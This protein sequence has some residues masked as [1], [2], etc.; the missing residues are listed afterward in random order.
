MLVSIRQLQFP[1]LD[2]GVMRILVRH[3]SFVLRLVEFRGGTVEDRLFDAPQL[4]STV[5]DWPLLAVTLAGRGVVRDGAAAACVAGRELIWA[6]RG[7]GIRA[8]SEPSGIRAL[9]LQWN[10]DVFGSP[11]EA[12]FSAVRLRAP[13]FAR[14]TG[15]AEHVVAAG[16]DA[17]RMSAAVAGLF[18][19][20]RAAGLVGVCPEPGDLANAPGSDLAGVGAAIDR[21]LCDLRAKPML[22]DVEG[23]LGR[24]AAQTRR[25]IHSCGAQLPGSAS[26]SWRAQRN[27]WRM[28]LGALLM[29]NPRGETDAVAK[30]LGYG[31]AVAFCHAFANAG[32]PSPGNIRRVVAQLA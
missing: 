11:A 28:Y 24:S 32:L 25:L 13:E 18:A 15:A 30:L 5:C 19:I 3:P 12:S 2:A 10:P 1:A 27:L 7:A 31:S 20:V 17:A 23:S 29:T 8:R 6:P 14:I 22:V 4:R 26:T 9:F 21:A 16:Y